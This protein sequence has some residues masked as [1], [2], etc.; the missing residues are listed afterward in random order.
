MSSSSATVVP[1]MAKAVS[2]DEDTLLIQS[3]Y[4]CIRDY[5]ERLSLNITRLR[6]S[7]GDRGQKTIKWTSY[8]G[9]SLGSVVFTIPIYMFKEDIT[10]G[11]TSVS[12][13][14]SF[15]SILSKDENSCLASSIRR[16]SLCGARNYFNWIKG[17]SRIRAY[18]ALPGQSMYTSIDVT[19]TSDETTGV[20]CWTLPSLDSVVSE[21]N[22]RMPPSLASS[23][24]VSTNPFENIRL[25]I[26]YNTS[27]VEEDDED[28]VDDEFDEFEARLIGIRTTRDEF[29]AILDI[30]STHSQGLPISSVSQAIVDEA[31]AIQ[32]ERLSRLTL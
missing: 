7:V 25:G 14:V 30:G 32:A 15:A 21:F 19:F 10:T 26:T 28:D 6:T 2:A 16:A 5:T 23:S 22:T 27:D 18:I 8:C 1:M 31:I 12:S 29:Q 20:H 3:I 13:V 17:T 11:V 4:R 24:V 9:S